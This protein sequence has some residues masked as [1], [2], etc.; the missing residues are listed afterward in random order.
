[1]NQGHALPTQ[2]LYE[3]PR[4]IPLAKY[5]VVRKVYEMAEASELVQAVE[6]TQPD[7]GRRFALGEV[8]IRA[9]RRREIDVATAAAVARNRGREFQDE[10]T[11]AVAAYTARAFSSLGIIEHGAV[12]SHT[13]RL[14][15]VYV[16]PCAR[17]DGATLVADCTLLSNVEERVH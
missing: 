13:P 10:Y 11:H 3:T 12:I 7:G 14:K 17:I 2:P 9:L 8:F 4:P 15:N 16:G 1:M 6:A 5:P